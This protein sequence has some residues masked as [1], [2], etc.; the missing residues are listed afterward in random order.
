MKYIKLFEDFESEISLGLSSN[1]FG[2][3]KEPIKNR[4]RNYLKNPTYIGW[5]D[6]H[7]ILITPNKTIWQAVIDIDPTFPRR[8]ISTDAKG[9]VIREWERIPSALFVK[10]AIEKAVVDYNDKIKNLN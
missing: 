1:M 9:K 7:S 3:L 10:K 6:I 5:N 4:I 2:R 8:G